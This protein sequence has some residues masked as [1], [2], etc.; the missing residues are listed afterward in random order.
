MTAFPS[1]I[2]NIYFIT[3]YLMW[4]QCL[5]HPGQFYIV[6]GSVTNADSFIAPRSLISG[7]ALVTVGSTSDGNG[8]PPDSV[9]GDEV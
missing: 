2:A 8:I 4:M 9:L 7:R 5:Y 6:D 1:L 3:T